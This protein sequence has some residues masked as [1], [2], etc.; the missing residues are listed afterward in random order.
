MDVQDSADIASAPAESDSAASAPVDP[1]TIV[2]PSPD[3]VLTSA[4]QLAWKRASEHESEIP[5]TLSDAI[6]FY[7]S[8]KNVGEVLAE[9]Q[10]LLLFMGLTRR[11]AA[12][13]STADNEATRGECEKL[14]SD[15]EAVLD[16]ILLRPSE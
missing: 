16:G 14:I 7:N 4:L 9:R 2:G 10:Y 8:C 1:P 11:L 12:D 15:I 3:H 6:E 13:E 5:R